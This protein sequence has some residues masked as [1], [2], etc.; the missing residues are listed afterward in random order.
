[1]GTQDKPNGGSILPEIITTINQWVNWFPK[2]KTGEEERAKK[3]L[4]KEIHLMTLEELKP[5]EYSKQPTIDV[6]KPKKQLSYE[7]A[8]Q[9][10][11][12]NIGFVPQLTD[13]ILVIDIDHCGGS[14]QNLPKELKTLLESK[15]CYME[16]SPRGEGIRAFLYLP[17]YKLKINLPSSVKA[18]KDSG[19]EGQVQIHAAY[20]TVTHNIIQEET[21][22]IETT[23][24]ELEPWF[25]IRPD[26]QVIQ[27]PVDYQEPVPG[28]MPS[29]YEVQRLLDNV[30]SLDKNPRIQRGYEQALNETYSHYNYWLTI[31]M[32][33]SDWGLK[34]GQAMLALEMWTKWSLSDPDETMCDTEEEYIKRWSSFKDQ[35]A[36]AL[37]IRTLLHIARSVEFEWP[38]PKIL[39][40]QST[41]IPLITEY[42]NY[43]YL[44]KHYNI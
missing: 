21:D 38:K 33:L 27:L 18:K 6:D 17:S 1:M 40:G 20:G 29:A 23:L 14:P 16:V 13:P 28:G 11:K 34:T 12:S 31:G 8:C 25:N 36:R 15:Q 42:A 2:F 3:D 4:N 32:C 24:E 37:T 43:E 39:K 35:G 41:N 5:Y 44:M 19:I 9:R 7:I 26:A 10:N 22:V 30:L